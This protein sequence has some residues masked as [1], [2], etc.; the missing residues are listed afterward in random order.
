K[1]VP[2]VS[3]NPPRFPALLNA[4]QGNPPVIMSTLPSCRISSSVTVVISC[5]STSP[6]VLKLALYVCLANLSISQK[7]THVCPARSS[8]SLNPP[9]PANKSKN[10][11]LSPTH[12][13]R[14]IFLP[15]LGRI[16]WGVCAPQ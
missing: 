2:L 11:I 15:V 5:H 8:A 6:S 3:S 1:S 7:P 13:E 12:I 10:V 9:I 16:Y 14:C 4:W